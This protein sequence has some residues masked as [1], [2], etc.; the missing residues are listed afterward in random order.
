MGPNIS[1]TMGRAGRAKRCGE[2]L[3]MM[4]RLVNHKQQ[5]NTPQKKNTTD[6]QNTP[7]HPTVRFTPC[8]PDCQ[9]GGS[10]N[11]KTRVRCALFVR[12]PRDVCCCSALDHMLLRRLGPAT[13]RW[14][15]PRFAPPHRSYPLI[16]MV[17]ESTARGERSFDIFSRLLQER[18]ICV[19]GP[20]CRAA[21]AW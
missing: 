4:H 3:A 13:R 1:C 14:P 9:G 18:I 16:P 15:A 7:P 12:N 19:N 8:M 17:V 2:R 20:V 6:T 21:S 10:V 5:N 11:D